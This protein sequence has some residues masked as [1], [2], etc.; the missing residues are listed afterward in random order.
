MTPE[1]LNLDLVR[2]DLRIEPEGTPLSVVCTFEDGSE[3][4]GH[5]RSRGEGSN[6]G[7]GP[8]VRPGRRRGYRYR[9]LR[10]HLGLQE[11]DTVP[12]SD[13]LAVLVQAL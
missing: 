1:P 8:P 13:G 3:I 12:L 5:V 6:I 2:V 11:T 4:R 10:S 7:L 9:D